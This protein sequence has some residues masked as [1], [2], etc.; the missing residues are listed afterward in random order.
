MECVILKITLWSLSFDCRMNNRTKLRLCTPS[1]TASYPDYF[2]DCHL[3][4]FLVC[5]V[6]LRIGSTYFPEESWDRGSE[7]ILVFWPHRVWQA[8][9]K[10][11]LEV[12]VLGLALVLTVILS[13]REKPLHYFM[14]TELFEWIARNYGKE[15]SKNC[16]ASLN[17]CGI[18][19]VVLPDG[20]HYPRK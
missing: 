1:L 11:A 10:V 5:L 16:I 17:C 4:L 3:R 14:F 12:W 7:C 15:F 13:P 9:C 2:I 18:Q 8:A 6:M 19:D 20:C